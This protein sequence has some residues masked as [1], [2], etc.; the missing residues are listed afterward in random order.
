MGL[1]AGG[2][3]CAAK[4]TFEAPLVYLLTDIR[5]MQLLGQLHHIH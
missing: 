1:K 2:S 5:M 4:P 3:A